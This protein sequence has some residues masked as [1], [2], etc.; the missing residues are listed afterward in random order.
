MKISNNDNVKVDTNNNVN[1]VSTSKNVKMY[2]VE[3]D[4]Y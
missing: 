3:N 1:F 2:F 4:M